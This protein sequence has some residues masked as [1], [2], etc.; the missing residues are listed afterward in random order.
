MKIKTI[1]CHDVY[2]L[3]ASLQAYALATYLQETG[4]DVQIINYKPL[5]LQ[6]YQLSGVSNPAY[7][8]SFLRQAYQIAKFP[9][10]LLERLTSKRKKRFD[11]FTAQYLPI[12]EQTYSSNEELAGAPPDADA[13]IAG[14]DQI[15]NPLFQNGKDP[16][17]FL[18]FVPPE[19]RRVSYAASFAV[20]TVSSADQERMKPWLEKFDTIS[21][22]E[23]SA[24]AILDGMG[25]TG[26]QVCD[27]VFLLDAPKWKRMA[28]MPE[29]NS[30]ILVYDFDS[31]PLISTI[32]RRLA[33]KTGKKIVSVFPMEGADAVWP[34]MGPLEFLGAILNADLVLSNS[35]H[36]TAFS[37][38]FHKEFYVVN[39]QEH[40]N[41]RMQD[42]LT[43]VK[44]QA[45]LIQDL[46]DLSL[47]E[48]PWAEVDTLLLQT[49]CCSK[50]YIARSLCPDE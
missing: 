49:V 2:N 27:P 45:R 38:I 33:E 42:L 22:R 37:L 11:D 6:H 46:G 15:W 31:N 35:F 1:T 18:D 43:S 44:L 48:I 9:G 8:K 25:V 30:Y 47:S 7:D 16:A 32:V 19:K 50:D 13:Y 41:T 4:H 40:I 34:D 21:V 24:L 17:F 5:Y 23:N 12:T 3:G 10:R 29:L 36:A 26:V 28:V 20:D 14:S 39:R